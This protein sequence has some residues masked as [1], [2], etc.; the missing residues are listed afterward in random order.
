MRAKLTVD[1]GE[2][3]GED[4][5]E[6]ETNRS[7]EKATRRSETKI[8]RSERRTSANESGGKNETE[9]LLN[10]FRDHLTSADSDWKT[11]ENS[12]AY[13]TKLKF[14]LNQV[15]PLNGN[16]R[17]LLDQKLMKDQWLKPMKESSKK[18]GTVRSY[19]KSLKLFMEFLELTKI[20]NLDVEKLRIM[21][22]QAE[23]WA[24]SLN[25]SKQRREF[26]KA[27]EDVERLV[28]VEEMKDF[29]SSKPVQDAQK[30]LRRFKNAKVGLVPTQQQFTLVRDFL[31]WELSSDNGMRPGPLLDITLGMFKNAPVEVET[32]NDGAVIHRSRVIQIFK[33]KTDYKHGVAKVCFRPELYYYYYY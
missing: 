23:Q 18:P 19:C 32:S 3:F 7:S 25:K 15:D 8:S 29:D 16:I 24:R 9:F 22:S 11:E 2:S 14:I 5:L 31:L 21:K 1:N 4:V 27:A 33:H 13:I 20:H 30:Y 10:K 12:Q 28:T 6:V 17:S 26:E